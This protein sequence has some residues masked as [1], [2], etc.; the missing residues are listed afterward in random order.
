MGKIAVDLRYLSVDDEKRGTSVYLNGIY[1]K[2]HTYTPDVRF[3]YYMADDKIKSDKN[4]EIKYVPVVRWPKRYYCLGSRWTLGKRLREDRPDVFHFT[5]FKSFFPLKNT[6]SIVT[7]LDLIPLLYRKEYWTLRYAEYF[8]FYLFMLNRARRADQIITISETSK[9]DLVFYLKIESEKIRVIPLGADERFKPVLPGVC[10][11][12]LRKYKLK[13]YNYFLYVG[14]YD[15]RKNI[16]F[17]LDAYEKYRKTGNGKIIL[18]GKISGEHK[19]KLEQDVSNMKYKSDVIFTDYI[20]TDELVALMNCATAFVFPSL[21]EGFGLP[22]IEAMKCNTPVIACN[23]SAA[24]EILVES[25][26]LLKE[27]EVS[28]LSERMVMAHESTFKENV[29]F[30]QNKYVGQYSWENA[31][32]KTLD[33]YQSVLGL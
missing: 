31:C 30:V 13:E 5:D 27:N 25:P 6:K 18:A 14:G 20:S 10:Q 12:V 11:G 16:P 21:Y 28:L 29:L 4:L 3:D 1:N 8:P 26:G 17:L 32:R 19:H 2:L 15:Y 24:E 7:I 23:S 22:I 33:I 9:R